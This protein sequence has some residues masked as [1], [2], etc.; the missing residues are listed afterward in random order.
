MSE[1]VKKVVLRGPVLTQSGYGTH[2]RQAAKWLL[3][4]PDVDVKFL[5]TPWGDT[6]WVINPDAY[7]GLA[8]QIMQHAVAPET[9]VR[10]S[11]VSFQFQLPNEWDPA[12]S[13]VNVGVSA[14]VET[15]KCNPTWIDACN[16]MD[17][18]IV[19]SQHAKQC[20]LNTGNVS[21][22]LIVVPESY[23]EAITTG[24]LPTLEDFSTDFNFLIFG[25][26]TGNNPHND[27][28]NTFFTIKWL[29]ETFA[30]NKDV[31][32]ILKTN[33]GRNSRIDRS[34]VSNLIKQLLAEVRKG[35]YPRVHLLHGDM[36]DK[37]VAALY[38]HRQVK[39]LV[40]LTRGEGYGLPILEAAASGLPIIATG[41]SG[42]MDFLKHGKFVNVYYQLAEVHK[43]RIDDVIF[44]KGSRWANPSEEDAKKRFLKFYESSSTPREWATDLQKKIVDT[45][46]FERICNAYDDV[47]KDIS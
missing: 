42:H 7:D 9:V 10:N 1:Q 29:C 45:Y 33:A 13:R 14:V 8:G 4:R 37:E 41:W 28:K 31:G 39:A 44:V 22:P 2:C 46:S 38:R 21:K 16:A 47:M 40:A 32:I 27:R 34:I 5:T 17:K 24:D 18:V 30:D 20:L 3:N 36:D 6:P 43:S 11:D 26:I 12:L 25:Q 15:D 19:P 35:P 23:N